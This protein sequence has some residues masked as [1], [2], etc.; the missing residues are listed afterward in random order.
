MILH[1]AGWEKIVG[2]NEKENVKTIYYSLSKE[3]NHS[4]NFNTVLEQPKKKFFWK[5]QKN[6]FISLQSATIREKSSLW[7]SIFSERSL[8]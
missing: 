1:Y 6:K 2:S 7:I 5:A 8:R 4:Q 3:K